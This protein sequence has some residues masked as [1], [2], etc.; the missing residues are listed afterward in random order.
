MR[1]RPLFFLTLALIVLAMLLSSCARD[2]APDADANADQISDTPVVT[3]ADDTTELE[4]SSAEDTPVVTSA[5]DTTEPEDS[6]AE[7]TPTV[8]AETVDADVVATVNSAP[9]DQVSLQRSKDQ[10]LNRYDQLYQQFGMNVSTFLAGAQGRIFELG[11]EE[12]ALELAITRALIKE[13]LSARGAPVTDEAAAAEF[14]VQYTQFLAQ[15]GLASDEAFREA[16]DSGQLPQELTAGLSYEQFMASARRSVRE[17]LEIRTL[18][19][20]VAGSIEP[21]EE[22]LVAFFEASREQYDQPEQVSASHILVETEEEA[23]ALMDE[24]DAGGSFETLA[25]ENSTCPSSAQGGALGWFG[26]GQMDEA[27]E[28]TAFATPV[29]EIS[30]IVE[31][32][33]GYHIIKVTDHRPAS[34]PA[35]EDVAD[36]VLEDYAAEMRM[37]RFGAWYDEAREAAVV[38]VHDPMLSAYRVWE[39]DTEQGLLAFLQLRNEGL[40][41]DPYLDFILGSIYEEMALEALSELQEL[42]DEASDADHAA[43][44]TALEIE[45][46]SLRQQALEAYAAALDVL[47][48]TEE[49]Q[50]RIDAVTQIALP[51]S[52]D[53]EVVEE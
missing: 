41:D 3:S 52:G 19:A 22:E 13:E 51:S 30:G 33:Y 26:R 37:E 24:L 1:I 12:E 35:F 48:D 29:G 5:D 46:E 10:V 42:T 45:V 14:D 21:S 7:D 25:R 2:N 43:R 36:Q 31:T 28:E 4:D 16:Y 18:Q 32:T 47:E 8:V 27:F 49:V 9:I 23:Q 44:I 17:D 38:V 50:A 39:T 15:L 53:S 40:V 11:I 34:V 20:L 6:S